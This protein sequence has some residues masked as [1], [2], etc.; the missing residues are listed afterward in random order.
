MQLI[1][2]V[3]KT[4]PYT[5]L[6]TCTKV[7]VYE[8]IVEGRLVKP[9]G[10]GEVQGRGDELGQRKE[11]LD[12]HKQWQE[13]QQ[14]QQ[15]DGGLT[16]AQQQHQE[17]QC[18]AGMPLHLDQHSLARTLRQRHQQKGNASSALLTNGGAL[19]SS[20]ASVQV[21]NTE[22]ED[23]GGTLVLLR[24][25]AAAEEPHGEVKN[26]EGSGAVTRVS[27]G[28]H[29]RHEQQ[30]QAATGPGGGHAWMGR[31]AVRALALLATF[32]FSGLEHVL[33][34]WCVTAVAGTVGCSLGRAQRGQREFYCSKTAFCVSPFLGS[35]S[36]ALH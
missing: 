3:Y 33:F 31:D 24:G 35:L 4:C 2:N 28:G 25:A 34:F 10:K 6:T 9:T 11:S 8:P 13:Q 7:L 18:G 14:Q 15:E 5:H 1:Q 16:Q 23:G 32:L 19:C 26:G 30:Q 29:G 17:M 36:A 21:A 12:K 20:R 22:G 27:T